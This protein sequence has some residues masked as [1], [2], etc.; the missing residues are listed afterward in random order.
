MARVLD[1]KTSIAEQL[2]ASPEGVALLQQEEIER[3][4]MIGIE[5]T[6]FLIV[7]LVGVWLIYRT[8]VR[9]EELKFHQQNF[10]M[11]VTHE[12]KTPLASIK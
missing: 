6:F 4:I 12:L 2:G 5:G 10:L 11:A 1:E 3:Q 8:L 7:L 9:T